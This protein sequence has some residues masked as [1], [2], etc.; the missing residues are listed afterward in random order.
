[1]KKS[2]LVFIFISSFFIQFNN[3]DIHVGINSVQAEQ[4]D[5]DHLPLATRNVSSKEE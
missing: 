5:G 3:E 4:M 1:M 2:I